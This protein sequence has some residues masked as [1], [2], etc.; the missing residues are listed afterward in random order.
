MIVVTV[1]YW[2]KGNPADPESRELGLA[3]ITAATA[4]DAG[5]VSDYRVELFDGPAD[6]RSANPW[7]ACTVAAFPRLKLRHWDLIYRAL[8][9][10]VGLRN[11][12]T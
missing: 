2:H 7:K 1:H 3:R 12:E 8:R 6:R 4:A 5:D 9:D 11:Q 10:L